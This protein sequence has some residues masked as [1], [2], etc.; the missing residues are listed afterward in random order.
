LRSAIEEMHLQQRGGDEM[1]G[2]A[3]EI[4]VLLAK[5]KTDEAQQILTRA[6]EIQ[7]T[8]WLANYRLSLASA[9]I[10]AKQ[11][12]TNISRREVQS[13]RSKAEKAGCGACE[14]DARVLPSKAQVQ[15]RALT[16]R[17]FF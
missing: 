11:G 14:L 6:E 9:E 13:E 10:D 3:I 2:L 17:Q 8:T 12:K 5:G 15:N 1:E 16:A 4:Q 7:N